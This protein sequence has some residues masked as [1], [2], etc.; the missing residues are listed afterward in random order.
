MFKVK[1]G[2]FILPIICTSLWKIKKFYKTTSQS[3]NI[4]FWKKN[5]EFYLSYMLLPGHPLRSLKINQP[6]RSSRLA[7]YT[8]SEFFRGKGCRSER[9]KKLTMG[10]QNEL[11]REMKKLPIFKNEQFKIVQ[12]NLKIRKLVYWTP[13]STL[14]RAI[15]HYSA[16]F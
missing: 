15:Q 6:I 12:S 1:C 14:F 11:F 4:L 3:A 9:K 7:R 8:T 2:G 10:E 13:N 16:Q 5:V